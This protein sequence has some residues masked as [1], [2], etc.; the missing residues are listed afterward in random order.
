MDEYIF[1][2]SDLTSFHELFSDDILPFDCFSS[3]RA[4]NLEPTQNTLTNP[5]DAIN[6]NLS[7]LSNVSSSYYDVSQFNNSIGNN[8]LSVL[9]LNINSLSKHYDEFV[10]SF[11]SHPIMMSPNLIIQLEIMRCLCSVKI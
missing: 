4:L 8:A 1:P 7:D 2:F 9:C 3:L 11:V 5:V 10:T 6:N